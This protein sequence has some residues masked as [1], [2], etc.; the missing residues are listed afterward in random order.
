MMAEPSEDFVFRQVHEAVSGV[1]ALES[2]PVGQG[3]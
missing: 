2:D 3:L 1:L